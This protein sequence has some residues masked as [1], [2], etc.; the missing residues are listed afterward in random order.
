MF[1]EHR[2][3]HSAIKACHCEKLES[4]WSCVLREERMGS[5]VVTRT[6][7]VIQLQ[8]VRLAAGGMNM[9]SQAGLES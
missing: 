1:I 9:F 5:V 4:R 7:P 2:A 6:L 3:V 8:E